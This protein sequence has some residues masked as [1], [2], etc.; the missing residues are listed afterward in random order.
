M[1]KIRPLKSQQTGIEEKA[2]MTYLCFLQT[3]VQKHQ[4]LCLILSMIRAQKLQ[5]QKEQ[6]KE[7]MTKLLNLQIKK[8]K[9]VMKSIK[10]NL[11][12]IQTLFYLIGYQ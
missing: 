8:V 11:C 12:K 9:K 4:S 3:R 1:T 10:T 6:V 5:V 7:S 2:W